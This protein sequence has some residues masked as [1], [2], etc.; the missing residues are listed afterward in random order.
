[1]KLKLELKPGVRHLTY[2]ATQAPP[3]LDVCIKIIEV[4]SNELGSVPS[5]FLVESYSFTE[6]RNRGCRGG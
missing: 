3:L 1:M 4:S 2:G 6:M 5:Y